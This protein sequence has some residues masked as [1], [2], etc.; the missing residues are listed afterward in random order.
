MENNTDD[1]SNSEK[2]NEVSFLVE[3]EKTTCQNCELEHEIGF[4]F[5]PH[6]GQ[7]T[8]DELTLGVL[9]Y[10]TLANY[11]SFD[12]RF[13]KSFIPLMF[14]PGILA[15]RFLEGKRLLY[16]HPAQMYLFISVVFFFLFT[17]I[18]RTQVESANK[19]FQKKSDAISALDSLPITNP[20]DSVKIKEFTQKLKDSKV[21][22]GMSDEDIQALDSLVVASADA[23]KELKKNL[24]FDFDQKK[25]DS[26]IALN[27]SDAQV[28]KAMGMSDDAGNFKR[29][30][31][32]QMLKFYKQRNAGTLLQ[33][34]YDTIP[35]AMFVLLPI[36]AFILKLLYYRRGRFSH[37]LV[38]SF[39]FF[40]FLF[41]VFSIVI[42]INF[43]WDI[44]DWIDWLVAV[45]T[46]FYLV[47]S[48]RRFYDQGYF[49]S[50]FKSS[51]ATFIFMPVLMIAAIIILG[52][53]FISY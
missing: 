32:S 8:N 1:S 42:L 51:I 35:I 37:H 27:A 20:I 3:D 9:F 41:T 10:N 29:K 17:F 26:L 49:W 11:F 40:S 39:Y 4:E 5:C 24:T 47:S 53:A 31:Y 46:F 12:A 50:F 13:F 22:T 7:K 33:A 21:A 52:F 23:N 44:P 38:F 19:M 18:S 15:K 36:F 34:F 48:T 28:Y 30:F 25:V 14:R 43:I 6:C 2:N 16:L 45:S